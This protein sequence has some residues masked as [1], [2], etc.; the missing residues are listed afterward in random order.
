[1]NS[2]LLYY[3]NHALLRLT[4]KEKSHRSHQNLFGVLDLKWDF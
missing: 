2:Q 4:A 1:M 3:L